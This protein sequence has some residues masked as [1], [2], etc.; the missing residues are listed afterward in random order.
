MLARA[1]AALIISFL[2]ILSFEYIYVKR[3]QDQSVPLSLGLGV[4]AALLLF[5]IASVFL[6]AYLAKQLL[7]ANATPHIK[8]IGLLAG[9]VGILW[10]CSILLQV[11]Q[12]LLRKSLGTNTY[13]VQWH[14]LSSKRRGSKKS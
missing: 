9:V 12:N 13:P 5:R 8:T 1:V 6:G 4:T 11:A 3:Y 2:V 10:A 14:R 7:P